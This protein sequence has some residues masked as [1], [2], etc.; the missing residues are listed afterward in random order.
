MWAYIVFQRTLEPHNIIDNDEILS[1]AAPSNA[2]WQK[3]PVIVALFWEERRKITFYV[4]NRVHRGQIKHVA[5]VGAQ[6]PEFYAYSGFV[7]GENS[8]VHQFGIAG[9]AADE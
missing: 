4:K 9:S 7:V 5:L 1:T 2:R 6:A 3:P 8:N